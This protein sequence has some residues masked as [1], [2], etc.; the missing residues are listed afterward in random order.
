MVT[1]IVAGV[2]LAVSGLTPNRL[3][4]IDLIAVGKRSG[5]GADGAADQR[6]LE[7]SADYQPA[8]RADSGADPAAAYRAVTG[9][10]TA[11]AEREQRDQK[12][13][14]QGDPCHDLP[15]SR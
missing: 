3:A 7:R 13:G 11:S 12:D 4:K 10:A 2:V 9:A 8:E 6:A 15:P 1:S 5:A 14:R